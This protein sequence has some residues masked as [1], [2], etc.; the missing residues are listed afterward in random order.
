MN[1]RNH[2]ISFLSGEMF[3][4]VSIPSF[5]LVLW[6]VLQVRDFIRLVGPTHPPMQGLHVPARS[7]MSSLLIN[8][9]ICPLQVS[10]AVLLDNF[11]AASARLEAKEAEEKI[12]EKKVLR[13]FKNPLEPL[14]ARQVA[15]N[16]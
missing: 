13:Q 6:V 5:V 10:L 2:S 4:Q 1:S 16:R 7:L 3:S 9:Y 11:V 15:N 8:D 14:V 12:A